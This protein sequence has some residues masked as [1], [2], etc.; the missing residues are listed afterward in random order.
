[1]KRA[2]AAAS[3]VGMR[4]IA[5]AAVAALMLV[6]VPAAHAASFERVSV[7]S[8]GEQQNAGDD[9]SY[10][11]PR[12]AISDDGCQIAFASGATNLAPHDRNRASDVFVRDRCR[13]TTELISVGGEWDSFGPAMTAD[14]RYV[15]F[16]SDAT[17]LV[18]GDTNGERD[19]F[20][21]DRKTGTTTRV[22]VDSAGR[23]A[24]GGAWSPPVISPDG[25]YVAFASDAPNLVAGDGNRETDVF[26]HDRKT[27]KTTLESVTSGEKQGKAFSV[28]GA[29]SP[30]GRYVAFTSDAKL[31]PGEDPD[32]SDVFVRDRVAGTTRWVRATGDDVF[33]GIFLSFSRDARILAIQDHTDV[34]RVDLTSG[35]ATCVACWTTGPAFWASLSGMSADGRFV[36]YSRADGDQREAFLYDHATGRSQLLSTGGDGDSNIGTISADGRY[37]VFASDATNLVKGDTN[38]R[39]DL[40]LW[41]ARGAADG[42]TAAPTPPG[43]PYDVAPGEHLVAGIPSWSHA[44]APNAGAAVVIEGRRARLLMQGAAGV[45]GTAQGDDR[46]GISSASA[47]FDGDG[48]TDLA[49]AAPGDDTVTILYGPDRAQVVHPAGTVAAGDLNG[50]DFADLVIG[51]TDAS[52]A[53]DAD[54]GSGVLQVLF[55][56]AS[57]LDVAHPRLIERPGRTQADFGDVLA[58]GDLNGDGHVDIAEGAHGSS[59]E[60]DGDGVPGHVTF[61]PGTASGPTVCERLRGSGTPG[62]TALATGDVT[63]DGIDD[64]VAGL[65]LRAFDAGEG[66]VPAGLLLLWRGTRSGP[67]RPERTSLPRAARRYGFETTVALADL[68]HDG[69]AD[70][71]VGS[72]GSHGG[73][74]EVRV[75]R[76][77]RRG[78]RRSR[79]FDLRASRGDLF[80]DALAVA[81]VTG[82]GRDDVAIGAEGARSVTIVPGTRRGLALRRARR[83]T[84]RTLGLHQPVDATF[85]AA[86]F[87][88]LLTPLR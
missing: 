73:R 11:M 34:V 47:D 19:M 45:P 26:V 43:A 42:G 27:G 30:D 87:G 59:F 14:G 64:L 71:L 81:D 76:G 72:P 88:A 56:S 55:G 31:A 29:I 86:P 4:S 25:R 68:D 83:I 46:F 20:V 60:D 17:K 37:V 21:R 7:S 58:L 9:W 35:T 13:H 67:S 57:G 33:S 53:E 66:R 62:P 22:D 74:G 40:F 28:P 5:S 51:D 65:P 1:M 38:R 48:H 61:C 8:S 2:A 78:L 44:G 12:T 6:A 84:R 54:H 50:D 24:R 10:L 69:H 52:P 15:A 79:T 70:A 85:A 36:A 80:G 75:Y 18:A 41:D 16:V 49:V 3:V 77:G 82:D 63:G 23:Q 32:G 39:T